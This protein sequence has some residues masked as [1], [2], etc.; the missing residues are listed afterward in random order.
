MIHYISY[1]YEY[2]YIGFNCCHRFLTS[3]TEIDKAIIE[4]Y[5]HFAKDNRAYKAT[6]ILKDGFVGS[7]KF[8]SEIYQFKKGHE[9][10]GMNA[11][12]DEEL[13][14]EF[15]KI[16][17]KHGGNACNVTLDFENKFFENKIELIQNRREEFQSIFNDT[18]QQSDEL[19]KF[20]E[21][22]MV[23]IKHCGDEA[24]SKEDILDYL[25]RLLNDAI[26]NKTAIEKTNSK[27]I[28]FKYRMIKIH[29]E[30]AKFDFENMKNIDPTTYDNFNDTE[31]KKEFLNKWSKISL[32]IGGICLIIAAPPVAV[33]ATAG[34]VWT[35]TLCIA[36][37]KEKKAVK[38]HETLSTRQEQMIKKSKI[39]QKKVSSISQSLN[40]LKKFR[41]TQIAQLENLIVEFNSL[42]EQ[43]FLPNILIIE[44]LEKRWKKTIKECEEYSNIIGKELEDDMNN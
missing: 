15:D 43:R 38:L 4:P 27:I 9:L 35:T 22:L 26:T 1:E 16:D 37:Y 31:S 33:I 10:V 14:A 40:N 7:S 25:N 11:N 18:I 34:A 21:D 17:T 41:E 5:P 23:L 44:R 2:E 36:K 3:F 29:D 32:I 6:D 42:N 13:E 12:L 8:V 28:T 19:A 39:L 30:L 20:G 24:A